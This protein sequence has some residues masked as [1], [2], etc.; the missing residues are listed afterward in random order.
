MQDYRRLAVWKR[1]HAL[2]IAIYRHTSRFPTEERYGLTSQLRR[3]ASSIPSNL[4]EGAGRRNDREMLRF[5]S[6]SLGSACEVEYQLL[7][8][9]ELGYLNGESAAELGAEAENLKRML[10]SFITT[11]RKRTTND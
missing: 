7:L 9:T 11:L 4:V 5:L 6:Y 10:N 3:A 2:T 8:A 1:S